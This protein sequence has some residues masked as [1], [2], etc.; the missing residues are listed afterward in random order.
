MC[1]MKKN[2]QSRCTYIV[3]GRDKSYFVKKKP[4]N[5]IL[6][7]NYRSF[8]HENARIFVLQEDTN[9]ETR[10]RKSMKTIERQPGINSGATQSLGV[11]A[12]LVIPVMLRSHDMDII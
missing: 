6:T 10:R 3:L 2:G 9:R 1:F 4:H 12:P 5:L 7:K 8:Y 11:P